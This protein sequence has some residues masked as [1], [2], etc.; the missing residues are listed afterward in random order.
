MFNT[1]K[2]AFNA[3]V[4]K[5]DVA[6]L[7]GLIGLK[8]DGWEALRAQNYPGMSVDMMR[9]LTQEV[10][11]GNWTKWWPFSD[12]PSADLEQTRQLVLSHM[13]FKSLGALRFDLLDLVL[14]AKPDFNKGKADEHFVSALIEAEAPD[15]AKSAALRKVLAGGIDKIENPDYFL[16]HAAAK[17]FVQGVDILAAAGFD[18]HAQNE[19]LLRNAAKNSDANLCLHLLTAHKADLDVAVRTARGLGAAAEAAW[20]ETFSHAAGQ[21]KPATIESLRAELRDL[22]EAFRELAAVVQ[23][24]RTPEKNLDKPVLRQ[25]PLAGAKR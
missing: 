11:A 21:E 15:E 19:A 6:A 12:K 3:A 2:K 17:N 9:L 22:R 14:E 24:M 4:R 13:A 5:N 1:R 7:R 18:V 8:L 16:A 25:E 23:D 10:D 20:L